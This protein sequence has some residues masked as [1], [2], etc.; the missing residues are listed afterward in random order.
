MRFIMCY[1][2]LSSSH[3][4]TLI[5]AASGVN[6]PKNRRPK[7]REITIIPIANPKIIHSLFKVYKSFGLIQVTNKKA[8]AIDIENAFY[9]LKLFLNCK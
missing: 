7:I 9:F 6:I 5:K 3:P 2:S 8:M 1:F 4:K